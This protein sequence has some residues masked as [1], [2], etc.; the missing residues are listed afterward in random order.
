MPQCSIH[1]GPFTSIGSCFS[2]VH[3][4]SSR[5]AGSLRIMAWNCQQSGSCDP[6]ASLHILLLLA[7]LSPANSLPVFSTCVADTSEPQHLCTCHSSCLKPSSPKHP[8]GL[9]L[10]FFLIFTQ[11]IP[12]RWAFLI[13]LALLYPGLLWLSWLR[14]HLQCRRPGFNPRVG[15]IPWRRERLPTTLF[16]PG[17]FCGLYSLQGCKESDMTE[18]LSLAYSFLIC[19]FFHLFNICLA[20]L[21]G[22]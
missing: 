8:N 18:Q 13:H 11:M 14:I 16:W 7:Q 9:L 19:C 12:S 15:K 22:S 10:Y 4:L 3:T 2:S 20:A 6:P 17:E 5:I 1:R 21:G